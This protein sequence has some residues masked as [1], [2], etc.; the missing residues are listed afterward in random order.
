M[1]STAYRSFHSEIRFFGIHH[2]IRC[3]FQTGFHA[4]GRVFGLGFGLKRVND[5]FE[6]I[7]IQ[8]DAFTTWT[9]LD[10]KIRLLEFDCPNGNISKYR[11]EGIAL[12]F[13]LL[14]L[15]MIL[16]SIKNLVL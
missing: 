4:V 5:I 11:I 6:I 16:K 2:N 14:I 8:P 12:F 3:L 10:I 7:K 15:T 9:K 13:E 1:R